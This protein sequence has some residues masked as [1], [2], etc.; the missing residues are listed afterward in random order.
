SAFETALRDA[1]GRA[2]D[3]AS[4]AEAHLVLADNQSQY[5]I[6]EE[7]R[8]GDDRQVWIAG[9]TRSAPASVPGVIMEKRLLWEQTD[10]ILDVVPNGN[11]LVVLSPHSVTLRGERGSQTAAVTS[12]RPWPRD[13]RG[14]LRLIPAGFK[15]HL[16]GVTCSGTFEPALTLDCR[17]I[18]EP[19]T[20]D[21]LS[22][23]VLLAN[24]AAARNYFDGR[25][26]SPA[27]VRKTVPAF[28]TIAGIEDQG[29]THWVATLVDGRT[30]ILDAAFE[31]AGTVGP[32]GSDVAAVECRCA[33]LISTKPGDARD[34][35]ELR[36]WSIV[37]RAAVAVA[38]PIEMPGPVTALW[39]LS[40][41]E[42]IAVVRDLS[43]GR[44]A[45]YLI[46]VVCGA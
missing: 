10:P 29:R 1:G 19:W 26:V 21:A 27:G 6:V 20:L 9:W 22:R 45:A 34:P 11:E 24:F 28:Y 23:G 40:G 37:N 15:V 5:L 18:D 44:Y 14:R 35:D 16:P 33:Q 41:A 25:V 12:I 7:A 38:P 46:K 31:P 8:K 36:A 30:Q 2:S 17:G 39:S 42:A 43:T 4:T 32:W 13:L 3:T